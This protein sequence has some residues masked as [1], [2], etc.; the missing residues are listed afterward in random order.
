MKHLKAM[1]VAAGCV[2]LLGAG[3]AFSI[4]GAASTPSSLI[5]ITPCRLVDTRSTHQLGEHPGPFAP[6]RSQRSLSSVHTETAQ[7]RPKRTQSSQT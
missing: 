4:A 5:P 7:S 3:V 1:A 2:S 6:A